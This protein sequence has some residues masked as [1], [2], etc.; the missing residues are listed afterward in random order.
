MRK[1]VE[2]LTM[3]QLSYQLKT[4]KKFIEEALE[5]LM[6]TKQ[7]IKRSLVKNSV[8]YY[9]PL[10]VML[11]DGNG[12]NSAVSAA[13]TLDSIIKQLGEAQETLD[14]DQGYDESS[15][16]TNCLI[17]TCQKPARESVDSKILGIE[18]KI[19]Q[20]KL[21]PSESDILDAIAASK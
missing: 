12:S 4:G 17:N 20:I 2:P 6:R 16:S 3:Q 21:T 7:V 8:V 5:N 19:K 1:K 18:K 13:R 15:T 14:V 9:L 10:M 11:D